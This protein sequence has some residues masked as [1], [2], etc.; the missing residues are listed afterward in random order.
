MIDCA[1]RLEGGRASARAAGRSGVMFVREFG[2]CFL[3]LVGGCRTS[4]WPG[5]W[6]ACA[7]ERTAYLLMPA[8]PT[9]IAARVAGA[10]GLAS[11]AKA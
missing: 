8:L 9:Y 5:W 10:T 4:V 6:S 1:R 11:R 2:E 7:G 3:G